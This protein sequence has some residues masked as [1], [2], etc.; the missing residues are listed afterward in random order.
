[1]AKQAKVLAAQPEDLRSTRHAELF[2]SQG[3]FLLGMPSN[4]GSQKGKPAFTE[5][6]P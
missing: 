2:C 1:M 3:V 5:N 4:S 6:Q